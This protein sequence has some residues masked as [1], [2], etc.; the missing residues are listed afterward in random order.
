M[1]R[2]DAGAGDLNWWLRPLFEL[3]REEADGGRPGA[4]AVFTRP[5]DVFLVQALRS[6]LISLQDAGRP[7]M[8][9]SNGC[10]SPQ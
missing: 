4:A 2:L 5:A 7:W 6:H 3:L 9:P 1:L 10:V 8:I